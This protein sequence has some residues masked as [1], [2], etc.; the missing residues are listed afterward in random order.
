[1]A[2]HITLY[3]SRADRP[4]W[5]RARALGGPISAI[6]TAALRQYL[7][8]LEATPSPLPEGWE[9][10]DLQRGG[11]FGAWGARLLWKGETV[12]V[13]RHLET[14][15][16]LR[17]EAQQYAQA[18]TEAGLTPEDLRIWSLRFGSLAQGENVY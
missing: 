5:D 15:D 14:K 16:A 8:M 2:D 12:H 7:E 11:A 4:L 3:V 6:A 18:A 10:T 17:L 13:L 9:L 1:M